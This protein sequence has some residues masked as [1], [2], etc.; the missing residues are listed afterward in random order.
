M[1]VTLFN[2]AVDAELVERNPF[3]ALSRRSRG[4]SD[5]H[6]PTMEEMDRLIAGCSALG[7]YGPQ[8]RSLLIFAAYSGMRPGELFALEWLDIDFD[9]KRI[10]VNRRLYRGRLDV[11]KSNKTR[12][13]VLTPPARDAILGHPT[14]R[15]GQL[16]FRAKRGGRLSQPTLSGYWAQV[17][18]RADLDFDFYL[19]TKHWCVHYMHATLGL[20]PQGDRRADGLDSDEC[21]EAAG[22]VWTRRCRSA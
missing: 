1:V 14:R 7:W 13:I 8:M 3:R 21:A 15:D 9:R 18:A 2:A 11:P 4:R 6:P 12:T 22:C 19:A 16:V 20:A 17:L 5:D 10:H